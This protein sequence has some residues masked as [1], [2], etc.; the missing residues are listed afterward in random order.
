MNYAGHHVISATTPVVAS[1]PL[2]VG[3]LWTDTSG[4]PALK[5]CTSISP[6]TF[7]AVGGGGTVA[8]SDVTFTDITTGNA[9]VSAHGFL[10]KLSGNGYESFR[11][12]GTY[13]YGIAR[14][15]ITADDPFILSQTW[16]SGAVTFRGFRINITK[17]AELGNSRI[18]SW[19][20][21]GSELAYILV[22]GAANFMTVQATS[23]QVS[24]SFTTQ[25]GGEIINGSGGRVKWSNGSDFKAA[26]TRN[27]D[28][29][30]GTDATTG[31][32]PIESLYDRYGTGSPEGA[33]TAPVG[34]VFHRTDGGAATSFY[35]KESGA[36][37]TGWVAK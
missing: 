8:D 9:S 11:G 1:S 3:F 20:V 37:N 13:K 10:P 7:V 32:C 6:V 24:A 31:F 27:A 33:V 18:Q 19:Y 5:I 35:V 36:G 34:A 12:D 30:K 22:T 28:G 21:D 14:G 26:L 15:T 2:A 23:M 4:T 16:N 29:I 17:T 25:A